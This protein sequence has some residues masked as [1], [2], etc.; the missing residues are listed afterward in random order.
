MPVVLWMLLMFSGSTELLSAEHTSRFLEPFLRWLYPG[1]SPRSIAA[2]HFGV[3]KLAHIT[4]YAILTSLLWSALRISL[5]DKS[6]ALIAAIA[7]SISALFA[8]SDEFHQSFVASRIAS[9]YDVMIDCAGVVFALGLCW[10]L[11]RP[12]PLAHSR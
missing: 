12:H 10:S 6:R 5:L 7:F 1:I 3:R 4:E 9:F 11:A 2:V 8:V